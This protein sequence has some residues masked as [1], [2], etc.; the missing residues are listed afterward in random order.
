M[1]GV[2]KSTLHLH[3]TSHKGAVTHPHWHTVHCTHKVGPDAA[4]LTLGRTL[5]APVTNSVFG[6]G[7][8]TS[9]GYRMGRAIGADDLA[10]HSTVTDQSSGN[11]NDRR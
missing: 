6:S 1:V 5:K 8:E 10:A 7:V 3:E 2:T 4:S 9:D 11:V